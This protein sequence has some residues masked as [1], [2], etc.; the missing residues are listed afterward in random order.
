MIKNLEPLPHP[1]AIEQL[2][3]TQ[4]TVGRGEIA[5]RHAAV[6]AEVSFT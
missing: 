4:M 6:T 2:R 1:V 5:R 3:P